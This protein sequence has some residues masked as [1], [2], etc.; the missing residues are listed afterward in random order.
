ME[1]RHGA[2]FKVL[3]QKR[4]SAASAL[5]PEKRSEIA[6]KAAEAMWEKRREAAKKKV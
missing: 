6:K 4:M 3:C 5:T 1:A 2:K